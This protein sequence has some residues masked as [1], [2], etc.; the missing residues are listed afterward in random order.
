VN[1]TNLEDETE[2]KKST[3]LQGM[4]K[5]SKPKTIHN[6]SLTCIQISLSQDL[7]RSCAHTEW[8]HSIQLL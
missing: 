2:K 7:R 8:P 4:K 3:V 6:P 1:E 5:W